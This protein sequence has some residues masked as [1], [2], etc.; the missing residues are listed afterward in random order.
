MMSSTERVEVTIAE[1]FHIKGRG[2]AAVLS[3]DPTPWWPVSAHRVLVV[4]PDGAA[5][6]TDARVEL[7]LRNQKDSM[8][9]IFPQ[10]EPGEVP[11]GSRVTSLKVLAKSQS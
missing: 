7:L 4:R 11:A 10:A 2:T 8:A 3:D 1:T 9:L 6:E 5:F